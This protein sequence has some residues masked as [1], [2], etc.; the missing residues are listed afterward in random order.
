LESNWRYNVWLIGQSGR[1]AFN[2]SS[3]FSVLKAAKL[4]PPLVVGGR[5]VQWV[6]QLKTPFFSQGTLAYDDSLVPPYAIGLVNS[7]FGHFPYGFSVD[8]DN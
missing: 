5:P 7:Y 3:G 1:N 6:I 4:N 2:L 8:P